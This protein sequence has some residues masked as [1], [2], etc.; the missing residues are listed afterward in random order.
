MLKKIKKIIAALPLVVLI[1]LLVLVLLLNISS[2]LML[3]IFQFKTVLTNSMEKS[4]AKGT[5]IVIQRTDSDALKKGDVISYEVGYDIV[6]HRISEI[7]KAPNRSFI[8]KGDSNDENDE[9]QVTSKQII[10]KV[11]AGIPYLGYI[12]QILQTRFGVLAILLTYMC[13]VLYKYC[14][15]Q[16]IYKN[17]N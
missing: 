12:C 9:G 15:S 16:Y 1:T 3:P 2:N 7:R 10:G 4:Y 17:G 11:I 8:T 5:L 6:T 14:I 13:F